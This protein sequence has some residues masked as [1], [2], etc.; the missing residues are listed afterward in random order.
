[1]STGSVVTSTVGDGRAAAGARRRAWALTGPV[2]SAAAALGAL[3][4]LAIVD[5][6]EQGHYPGCPFLM[7]TGWYCPGC[8]SLRAL[9][10]LAHGDVS[11][12]LAR[13]PLTVVLVPVVVASWAAWLVRAG[14]GRARRWAAPAWSIWLLLVVVVM[15]TIARNLPV[16]RFLAP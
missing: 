8:G 4:Y 15:F 11:T 14:T 1:M 2:L 12:A 6:N 9:H 3:S 13:N 7:V 5:P 16:G 10:A